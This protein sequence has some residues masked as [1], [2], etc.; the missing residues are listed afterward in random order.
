MSNKKSN[1]FIENTLISLKRQY[2][3]NE[4]ISALSRYL[5]KYKNKNTYLQQEN[6]VLKNEVSL[7][8][9]KLIDAEKYSNHANKDAR[10]MAR[11][12]DLY[13]IQ[14]EKNKKILKMCNDFRKSRDLLLFELNK[15]KGNC[16]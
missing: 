11:K 7:L 14:L 16:Q 5:K 12:E 8:K 2:S 10:V 13:L 4:T 9:I 6:H 1:D 3:T 15:L